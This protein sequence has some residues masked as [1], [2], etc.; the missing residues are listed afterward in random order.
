MGVIFG[1]STA[2]DL[3]GDRIF[4]TT[5]DQLGT[6]EYDLD[7]DVVRACSADSESR[8]VGEADVDAA[9]EIAISAL[10]PKDRDMARREVQE[11]RGNAAVAA[12]FPAAGNQDDWG[13]PTKSVIVDDLGRIWVAQYVAPLDTAA[14]WAVFAPDCTYLGRIAVNARFRISHIASNMAVGVYQDSNLVETV[15]AYRINWHSENASVGAV[16]ITLGCS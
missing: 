7:G 3:H 1:K 4:V 5:G 13:I 11:L 6:R 9:L 15:R 8:P 12:E 2:V 10:S 16:G 14:Y